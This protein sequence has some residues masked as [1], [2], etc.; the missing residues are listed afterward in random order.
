[1]KN[2]FKYESHATDNLIY[3]EKNIKEAQKKAD[4]I[5]K[6]YDLIEKAGL[7]VELEILME[8]SIERGFINGWDDGRIGY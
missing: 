4:R 5:R 7:V 1:M 8:E 3:D 6:A 2:W